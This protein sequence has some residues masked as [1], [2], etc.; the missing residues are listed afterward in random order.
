MTEPFF[1]MLMLLALLTFTAINYEKLIQ[2]D[3][4]QFA[5]ILSAGAL[6]AISNAVRPYGLVL[7]SAG[8]LFLVIALLQQR[9]T[10]K[11]RWFILYG[12]SCILSL[13]LS[14]SLVSRGITLG[15]D[16]IIHIRTARMPIGYS[17]NVGMNLQSSGRWNKDDAE[18]LPA[19][20]DTMPV[21]NAQQVQNQLTAHA[22]Q[23]MRTNGIRNLQLF[24][25]KFVILW[26]SESYY[27]AYL[28]DEHGHLTS[29]FFDIR[30]I[31]PALSFLSSLLACLMAAAAI[32][33]YGHLPNLTIHSCLSLL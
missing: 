24:I 5:I 18:L 14:Y 25:S 28:Y 6:F 26:N 33:L 13:F 29:G 7:L 9:I 31:I 8:I 15:I 4:R 3:P 23:R 1:V 10:T 22:I 17:L 20:E 27:F 30:A 12:V 11:S 19:I 32:Q 21:F 2:G 16:H